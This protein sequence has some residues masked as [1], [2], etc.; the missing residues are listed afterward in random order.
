MNGW[1]PVV[2]I[3]TCLLESEAVYTPQEVLDSHFLLLFG[4]F[5]SFYQIFISMIILNDVYD[6][7]N[8][9]TSSDSAINRIIDNRLVYRKLGDAAVALAC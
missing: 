7:N 1:T 8:N 9:N 3:A 5:S 2:T 6:I 4:G